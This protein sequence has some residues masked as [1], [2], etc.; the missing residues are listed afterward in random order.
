MTRSPHFETNELT[1]VRRQPPRASYDRQ[2]AYAIIDEALV[3]T[4]A[5]AQGGGPFAIPMTVGRWNDSVVLHAARSSR[6]A[7]VLGSGAS[8]CITVALVDGLVL[9]RSAMHHSLN[10]RSVVIFGKATE[11]TAKAEKLEALR[12]LV[13]HVLAGRSEGCRVP[14]DS[15]LKATSVFLI[16]LEQVSIKRRTGGPLDDSDDLQ[17][18]YW[19]GEIPLRQVPLAPRA[20]PLHPPVNPD[21]PAYMR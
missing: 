3:A 10:Y 6:F 7:K 5:F 15:E 17:L 8:V 1:R 18:P 21:P 16:P 20:D 11:V 14:N 2:L 9:A 4:V 19:A 12:A 13:D